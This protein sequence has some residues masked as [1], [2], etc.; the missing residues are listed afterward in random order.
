MRTWSVSSL[1]RYEFNT[2]ENDTGIT[3]GQVWTME[4]G[5]GK[6]LSPLVELGVSGYCQLQTTTDSGSGAS[7]ALDRTLAL[8]PEAT[9]VWPA[10][11]IMFSLRYLHEF[12]VYD[13]PQGD[14]VTL[15]LTRRF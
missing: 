2:E 13:R 3:P 6:G 15:T 4:W 10:T 12:N 1:N 8:G 7:S 9:V 5:V 14:V 11:K